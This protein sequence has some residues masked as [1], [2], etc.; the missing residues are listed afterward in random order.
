M[1]KCHQKTSKFHSR[2]RI[3]N[4]K[5]TKARTTP[6]HFGMS[7]MSIACWELRRHTKQQ[8]ETHAAGTRA[9][10]SAVGP[11]SMQSIL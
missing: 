10:I 8:I 9:T 3:F 11:I 6:K 5:A 4:N 7:I 2:A 1:P